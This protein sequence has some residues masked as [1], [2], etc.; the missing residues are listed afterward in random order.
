MPA[1]SARKTDQGSTPPLPDREWLTPNEVARAFGI[2]RLTLF[3]RIATGQIVLEVDRRGD[4]TFI[5]RASVVR[6]LE[7][8]DNA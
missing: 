3:Q 8:A 1:A 2:A 7:A 6:A 4:M 5:T